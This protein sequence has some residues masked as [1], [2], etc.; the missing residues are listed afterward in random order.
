MQSLV[1]VVPACRRASRAQT[2]L[3]VAVMK[4]LKTYA[5]RK[6]ASALQALWW[7]PFVRVL[8]VS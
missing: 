8:C 4:Q 6:R 5:A 7:S 2:S 3:S 1:D